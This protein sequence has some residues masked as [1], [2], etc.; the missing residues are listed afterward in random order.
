MDEKERNPM[1]WSRKGVHP[2][3]LGK[4]KKKTQIPLDKV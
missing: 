2:R 1:P 3:Q 4:K